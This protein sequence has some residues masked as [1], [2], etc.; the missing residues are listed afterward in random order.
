MAARSAL[1]AAVCIVA[2]C[3]HYLEVEDMHVQPVYK[4]YEPSSFFGDGMSARPTVPGTVARGQLHVDS[5]YD[6]GQIEGRFVDDLPVEVDAELLARGRRQFNI[7]CSV[8]HGEAGY[9]DG[10]IVQ[11]G[12]LR[13]PSLH[14]D[15]LRNAPDGY[16]FDV[17]T[18]G[19]GAMASYANQVD[20]ADRW[21]IVAYE[22]ALQ[23]SQNASLDQLS[24]EAR[25]AL[26]A[27]SP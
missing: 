22:R 4:T 15:R 3:S 20:I 23:L 21:A 24:A 7:F 9:G 10:M 14:I 25:R 2:G 11:R 8:C 5:A 13:P 19:L 17:I 26:E 16:L 6:R 1:A 12:F 27:E 18:N